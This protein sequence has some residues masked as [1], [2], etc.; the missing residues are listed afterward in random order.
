MNIYNIH[1]RLVVEI[2]L[3]WRGVGIYKLAYV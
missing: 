2:V 1:Q 3:R